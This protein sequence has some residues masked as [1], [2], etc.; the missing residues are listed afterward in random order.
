MYIVT[1]EF[2]IKPEDVQRFM[3]LAVD[4]A[5]ASRGQE[6]G[7]W[8]FDVCVMPEAPNLVFLYEVYGDRGAFEAHL[9][10]AHY[11]SF[12]AAVR[13]MVAGKVVRTYVRADP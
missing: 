1:V 8:Q 9:A 4:N 5:R 2:V 3:P 13:D 10:T 11:R 12:D 7:C 6:P